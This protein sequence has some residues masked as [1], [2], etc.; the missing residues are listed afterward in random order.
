MTADLAETGPSSALPVI[1]IVGGVA[2]AAG[3]GAMFLVRRR[4]AGVQ[5]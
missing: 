4:K 1:G 2:V 5:V 3:A